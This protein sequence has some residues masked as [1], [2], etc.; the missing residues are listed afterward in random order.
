M[1]ADSPTAIVSQHHSIYFPSP[2]V[3]TMVLR[4]FGK[5]RLGIINWILCCIGIRGNDL[6]D[7]LAKIVRG[8]TLNAMDI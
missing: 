6:A 7:K 2:T 3:I 4:V 5:G 1:Y 8:M